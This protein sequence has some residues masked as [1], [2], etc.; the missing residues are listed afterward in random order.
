MSHTS[1]FEVESVPTRPAMQ[2]AASSW[3]KSAIATVA[4]LACGC[5]YLLF[6]ESGSKYYDARMSALEREVTAFKDTSKLQVRAERAEKGE[7]M[8]LA[9]LQ[10]VYA[11]FGKG[12]ASSDPVPGGD[13]PT[14]DPDPD[15]EDEESSDCSKQERAS[16]CEYDG[17][18]G[19]WKSMQT[20]CGKKTYT[21]KFTIDKDK[22]IRCAKESAPSFS[23]KCLKCFADSADFGIQNCKRPCISP[24]SAACDVCMKPHIPAMQACTGFIPPGLGVKSGCDED[25]R[26]LV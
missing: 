20:A 19:A 21:W 15:P 6:S 5:A 12:N 14:P 4:V 11:H 18:N 17:G 26:T 7:Q 3:P 8:L 10:R 13:V 23:D 24:N 22:Y 2:P 16:L 9:E 25:T 1:N